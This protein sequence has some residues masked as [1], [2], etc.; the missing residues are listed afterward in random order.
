MENCIFC[1]IINGELQ[2]YKV[3]EDENTLSF[4][5][6]RPVSAYHT[7][8]VPKLHYEN[9]FDVPEF[10]LADIMHM[11]K[12]VLRLY[13]EKLGISNV[14]LFNNSGKAANQSVF[15]LHYHI[16]P[17]NEGDNA[18]LAI[19]FHPELVEKYDSMLAKLK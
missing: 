3:L 13:N 12:M 14:Q 1:K 4:L 8:V 7:L 2:S 9:M 19:Q 5:D 17:R 10:V 6:M 15:H 18:H 11:V 16:I